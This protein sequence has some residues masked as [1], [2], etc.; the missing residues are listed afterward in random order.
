MMQSVT[1]QELQANTGDILGQLSG[2]GEII[3]TD[4]GTP[5]AILTNVLES[6]V[7][8]SLTALRRARAIASVESMQ[9]AAQKAGLDQ[10]SLDE[11]NEEIRAAREHR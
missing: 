8:R 9:D 1:V 7:E 2:N 5:I 6:D 3:V 4:R 11:I 10:M